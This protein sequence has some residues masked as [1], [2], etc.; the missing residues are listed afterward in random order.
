MDQP[1]IVKTTTKTLTRDEVMEE[2]QPILHRLKNDKWTAE[3]SADVA[4][5]LTPQK[6]KV[7]PPRAKASLAEWIYEQ[8]DQKYLQWLK[9]ASDDL[10]SMTW[11]ETQRITGAKIWSKRHPANLALD[12]LAKASG[13]FD[14]EQ[15]E[16]VQAGVREIKECLQCEKEREAQQLEQF[17]ATVLKAIEKTEATIIGRLDAYHEEIR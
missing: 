10:L 15:R 8:E 14:P 3:L 16:I 9:N 12:K 2:M 11:N 7:M 17:T 6:L 13:E 4:A 1:D 5:A